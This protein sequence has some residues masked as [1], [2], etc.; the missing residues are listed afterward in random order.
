MRNV[1]KPEIVTVRP[2]PRPPVSFGVPSLQRLTGDL[3]VVRDD[4]LAGGTK[5]RSFAD[6]YRY[7]SHVVYA[8]PAQGG[9]QLALAHAA[10]CYGATATV[11]V[12]KRKD[13]HPRTLAAKTAGADVW[14]VPHGYLNVVQARARDYAADH[15]AYLL[16]FGGD[17][18][19]AHRILRETAESVRAALLASDDFAVDEVWC[20]AGSGTLSRALQAA[21]PGSDH[22]AVQ[23]GR[24]LTV[25]A[26]GKATVV[27]HPL[28]FDQRSDAD[29]PFP[30]DPHYDRKAWDVCSKTYAAREHKPHILFWN[31]LGNL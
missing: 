23:V 24:E 7:H 3:V 14:Q 1:S 16:P 8:S 21:F 13:P 15:K 17:T 9:A 31:V 19:Q 26:A 25:D 30:S 6:L 10:K 29:C 18:V 4:L 12:A 5:V 11:F 22:Y 28:P 2:A 27:H 20:A